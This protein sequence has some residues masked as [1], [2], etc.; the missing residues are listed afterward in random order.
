VHSMVRMPRRSDFSSL[1]GDQHELELDHHR[2]PCR[3]CD[4][5]VSQLREL[6]LREIERIGVELYGENGRAS[7][8]RLRG[9]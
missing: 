6:L 5:I 7:A 8:N 2:G 1:N 9:S 4:A 3:I